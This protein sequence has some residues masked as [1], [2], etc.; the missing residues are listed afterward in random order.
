MEVLFWEAVLPDWLLAVYL[1]VQRARVSHGGN[2]PAFWAVLGG[3]AVFVSCSVY[4]KTEDRFGF[5]GT[6]GILTL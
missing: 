6:F 1:G 5:W 3:V 4:G 2:G